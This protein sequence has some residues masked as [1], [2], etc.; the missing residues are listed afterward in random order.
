VTDISWIE[1]GKQERDKSVCSVAPRGIA[2]C[3]LGVV[4]RCAP[5]PRG[6]VD[7]L[8]GVCSIAP[9]HRA[10]RVAFGGPVLAEPARQDAFPTRTEPTRIKAPEESGR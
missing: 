10:A 2:G 8:L 3:L 1:E 5:A 4:Q 9:L 7:G 6:R